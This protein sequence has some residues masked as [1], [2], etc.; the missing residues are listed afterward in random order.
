V[1]PQSL[2]KDIF[3]FVEDAQQQLSEWTCQ[4][5]LAI[6]I[7]LKQFLSVLRWFR[8]V[9]LQDCAVLFAGHPELPVFQFKPFSTPVFREFAAGL[10][11]SVTRAEQ[12]ARLAFQNLPQHLIWS[13]RG[14]VTTLTLEQQAQCVENEALHAEV[15][16]HLESQSVLLA[17]LARAPKGHRGNRASSCTVPGRHVPAPTVPIPTLSV[18]SR[19]DPTQSTALA[20]TTPLSPVTSSFDA[21]GLPTSEPVIDPALLSESL[22]PRSEKWA[23]LT[24]KYGRAKLDGHQWEWKGGDWLPM[25][26]YQPVDLITDLW[27]EHVDG[28]NGHLL[29]RE[30]KDRW[31]ARWQWNEGGLK[32]EG[33]RRAK[34]VTLIEQLASKVNWDVPLALRFL[35]EKYETNP[36]YLHKVHAFCDYLQKNK[37]AGFRAVLDAANQ[38]P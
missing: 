27:V 31:G 26:R 7:A 33:G 10:V 5:S 1:P 23:H 22:D 35:K 34:V 20:V 16:K 37:G 24:A 18:P 15:Q 9:L 8:T 36:G 30:L 25:Y 3:P 2:L 29:A 19:T 28:L 12:E 21:G 32:T 13:L 4:S 6:D 17:E 14:L 38:Y 11:E